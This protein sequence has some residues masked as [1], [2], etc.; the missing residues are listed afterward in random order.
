V[1]SIICNLSHLLISSLAN[2]YFTPTS[3]WYVHHFVERLCVPNPDKRLSTISSTFIS[4]PTGQ[5]AAVTLKDLLQS[6]VPTPV[7]VPK[8]VPTLGVDVFT[9][10]NAPKVMLQGGLRTYLLW[11][12]FNFS[13]FL[14]KES[15]VCVLLSV[16]IGGRI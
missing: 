8:P 5:K 16:C 12:V 6:D 13:V 10:K 2:S 4:G 14:L 9:V 3:Y 7:F 11:M 15:W 1:H